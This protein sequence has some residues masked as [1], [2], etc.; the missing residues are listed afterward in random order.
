MNN[1]LAR[2]TRRLHPK[3]KKRAEEVWA[4]IRARATRAMLAGQDTIEIKASELDQLTL[5]TPL[6]AADWPLIYGLK[7]KILMEE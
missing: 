2:L 5:Y 4:D 6:S 7:I 1:L 3:K